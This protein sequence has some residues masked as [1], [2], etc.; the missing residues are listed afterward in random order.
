MANKKWTFLLRI[1]TTDKTGKVVVEK[2]E[3]EA[4]GI[5]PFKIVAGAKSI[6]M[7]SENYDRLSNAA[8]MGDFVSNIGDKNTLS[9]KKLRC[10]VTDTFYEF[11]KSGD[12]LKTV[13]L[14]ITP[15][16]AINGKLKDKA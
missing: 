2:G 1:F 11:K 16:S 13:N 6:V 7:E 10:P 9:F 3:F 15:L 12:A 4:L 8:A 14:F 5:S